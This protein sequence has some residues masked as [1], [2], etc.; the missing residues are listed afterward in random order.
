MALFLRFETYHA[1]IYI[2]PAP[3][4]IFSKIDHLQHLGIQHIKEKK[5]HIVLLKNIN[6]LINYIVLQLY[7]YSENF[8]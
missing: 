5:F 2:N 6:F 4:T 1:M 8:L 7:I 3:I